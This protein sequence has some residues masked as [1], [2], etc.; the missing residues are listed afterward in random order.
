MDKNAEVAAKVMGW[1]PVRPDSDLWIVPGDE[2]RFAYTGPKGRNLRT[3]HFDFRPWEDIE[4][5]WMVVNHLRQEGFWVE[6]K[7]GPPQATSFWSV[8]L[9]PAMVSFPAMARKLSKSLPEAICEAA[10]TVM[11]EREQARNSPY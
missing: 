7:A 9:S 8:R 11:S 4:A 1:T 2:E 10:L 3:P 6:I 5:A